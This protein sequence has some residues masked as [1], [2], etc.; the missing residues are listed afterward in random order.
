MN[1][2]L[3]FTAVFL[4][5]ASVSSDLC[6]AQ[7][8]GITPGATRNNDPVVF[9]TA[10]DRQNMLD[11]LGI[12]KLRPGRGSNPDSPNPANYDQAKANPYP[13]LPEILETKDGKKVTTPEQWWNERRPEIVEL[14]EREVYGRIPENVPKVRWE[15]RETREVKAGGKPAIQ[16]HIVGVVDKLACPQIEVNISMSLTLPKETKGPVPVLMSF[17]WTPFEPSPFGPRGPGGGPR[18]PSKED[19]LIAAGW[20]CATLN[21]STVQ[22]DSG[23]WQPRRFGPGADPDAKP[24]GA[25][26][27]R[28]IIGLTNH[29]QPRKPDQW[30][31]LRAWAWGASRGLDYLETVPEVDT[32]RV[33]IAGVSRYGKA[34]LVAM[35]F[36]RRIAVGLI[37]SSGKG[38]TA[39]YRRDFG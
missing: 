37:A 12:K 35:A 9:T 30:G 21:P 38:G 2:S 16:R 33:G 17:G 25:G 36:D 13:K 1:R 14:L 6:S 31:A 18:P 15:V 20:G 19:T 7:D 10:Q 4:G 32:K 22:A 8:G 29:G 24:T 28:G 5:I 27:T 3:S 23:G 39:L 34:A 11:Q 26:L